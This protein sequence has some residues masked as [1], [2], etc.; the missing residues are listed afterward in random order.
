MPATGVSADTLDRRACISPK[1]PIF[2]LVAYTVYTKTK[3]M[4]KR[5]AV[6]VLYEKIS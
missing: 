3:I 4:A 2:S 5:T 6:C 1:L